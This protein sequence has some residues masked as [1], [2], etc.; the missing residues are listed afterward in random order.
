MTDRQF[1]RMVA[2]R[3]GIVAWRQLFSSERFAHAFIGW[4]Y[5]NAD[6][7]NG[8]K[9]AQAAGVKLVPV[10]LIVHEEAADDDEILIQ[11]AREADSCGR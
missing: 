7:N 6:K 4:H 8:W 9:L 3:N 2:V 11:R 1:K 5:D 10:T